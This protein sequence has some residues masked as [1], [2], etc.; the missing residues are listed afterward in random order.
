M[1]TETE[2][3]GED[4]D[5]NPTVTPKRRTLKPLWYHFTV[6][7]RNGEFVKLCVFFYFMNQESIIYMNMKDM[8]E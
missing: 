3:A 8:K 2:H 4:E 6:K 1:K 5:W 7:V